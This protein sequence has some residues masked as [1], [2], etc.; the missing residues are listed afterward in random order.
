MK[1]FLILLS[2][3]KI[4]CANDQEAGDPLSNH[5]TSGQL[6]VN[7]RK[8]L[9]HFPGMEGAFVLLLPMNPNFARETMRAYYNP[10][11]MRSPLTGE[12][13]QNPFSL[14]NL[15]SSFTVCLFSRNNRSRKA[16]TIR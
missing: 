9:S 2:T 8:A 6:V 7:P 16:R 15:S 13:V 12:I 4:L 5:A 11:K 10:T 1:I 3:L 14:L